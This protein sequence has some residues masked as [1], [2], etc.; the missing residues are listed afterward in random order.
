MR[1]KLSVLVAL[2][3]ALALPAALVAHEGHAHKLMGTVAAVDAK[4]NR[5]DIKTQDGQTVSFTVN[6]ETRY[7][8]GK[9]AASLK[10][11]QVGGRVVATVVKEGGATTASEVQLSDG[12]TTPA[13]HQH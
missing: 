3:V 4:A 10:D 7:L 1:S 11:V 13:T 2:V 6:G 8:K 12:G 9:V 5:I